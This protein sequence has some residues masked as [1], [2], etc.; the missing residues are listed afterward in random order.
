LKANATQRS[1]SSI[2]A[3]TSDAA[4]T[5]TRW[6]VEGQELVAPRDFL[7]SRKPSRLR[8]IKGGSPR[9][10]R[11]GQVSAKA[12]LIDSAVTLVAVD[13]AIEATLPMNG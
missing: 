3:C 4:C 6:N 7:V 11:R 10:G 2:V 8:V 5:P 13:A 9:L 12:G 1:D